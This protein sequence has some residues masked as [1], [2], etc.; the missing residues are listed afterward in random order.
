MRDKHGGNTAIAST[1]RCMVCEISECYK[2]PARFST[3]VQLSPRLFTS[4]HCEMVHVPGKWPDYA[5]H[6]RRSAWQEQGGRHL[7]SH[8][9]ES[10]AV[11]APLVSWEK[12]S[13]HHVPED[14]PTVPKHASIPHICD[15]SNGSPCTLSY[16][17][18]N[19]MPNPNKYSVTATKPYFVGLPCWYASF[20]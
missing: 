13:I 16:H 11:A 19:S 15:I 1:V 4:G 6:R 10:T 5:S 3:P 7:A 17:L 18:R 20:H 9:S 12:R 8:D 2:D 14:C